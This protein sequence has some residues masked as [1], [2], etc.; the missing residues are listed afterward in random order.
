MITTRLKAM[1][2]FLAT[3]SLSA[4][5]QTKSDIEVL[6]T[7][8]QRGF[9][10]VAD[11]MQLVDGTKLLPTANNCQLA[12]QLSGGKELICFWQFD[13]RSTS[14]TEH[15]RRLN[16]LISLAIDQGEVP[17]DDQD[18]NHPDFYDLRTYT[19][20]GAD[21]AVS[22]KDKAALDQTFVFLRASKS[23]QP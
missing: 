22:L 20:N 4:T 14:A 15:L 13:Y 8:A 17:Q 19:I 18:V 2:W 3:S 7:H 10:N 16:K 11:V 21:I 5:A 1:A 12:L 6:L 23:Q 9:V